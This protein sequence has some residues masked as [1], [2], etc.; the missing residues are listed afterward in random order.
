MDLAPWNTERHTL[1]TTSDEA[2]THVVVDGRD[3]LV[4]FHF[5]GVRE[6]GRWFVTSQMLYGSRMTA[7]LGTHVYR[8]YLAS[9]VRFREIVREKIPDVGVARR[10]KG[11]RGV[12]FSLQRWMIDRVSIVTGNAID[13]SDLT[14]DPRR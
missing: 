3:P 9:L 11:V 5:H 6:R 7:I 14:P 10:G 8:P 13:S 12:V 1:T 2:G 4:F